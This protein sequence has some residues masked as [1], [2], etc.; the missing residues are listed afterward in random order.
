MVAVQQAGRDAGDGEIP[1]V[2]H[3][4][5]RESWLVTMTLD[6]FMKRHK[7]GKNIERKHIG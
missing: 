1:T 3:R 2:F 6:D 4:R 7:G 5:N